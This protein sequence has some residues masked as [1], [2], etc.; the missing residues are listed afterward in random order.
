MN[1]RFLAPAQQEVDEAVAWYGKQGKDIS[2][3]FL[4]DLDRAVRLAKT[5][6]SLATEIEPEIRRLLFIRYPYSLVYGIDEEMIVIV[7]VAH[8]QRKPRYWADRVIAL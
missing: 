8:Q 1:V 5:Y 4:D 7:A 3:G 2:R 6:P